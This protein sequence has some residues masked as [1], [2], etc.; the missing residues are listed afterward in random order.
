M[1]FGRGSGRVHL[2][3]SRAFVIPQNGF[4]ASNIALDLVPFLRPYHIIRT[5]SGVEGKMPDSLPMLDFSPRVPG[6]IHAF[7]FSGHG[8][9]LGPGTGAVLAELATEGRSRTD[10][11]GFRIARFA[12]DEGPGTSTSVGHMR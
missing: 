7:G 3:A 1:L 8:F 11:T 12:K 9:Q 2:E 6:L 4:N 5:W 10:I